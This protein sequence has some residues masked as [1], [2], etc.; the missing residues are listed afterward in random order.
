[1][2]KIILSSS[3]KHKIDEIRK[4]LEDLDVLVISKDDLGLSNF[5]VIEDGDTLEE[6]AIKKAKALSEKVDGIILADDTGLFVDYLNGE[7]GVRS[8]RF[9]GENASYLDNNIKLLKK[10][11]GIPL[12]KRTAKF[13]TVIAIVFEDKSIKTVLGECSGKIALKPSGE[14]GFGYDPLFIVDDY[15][16]TF[17]ELGEEIKNRISHRANALKKLKELLEREMNNENSSI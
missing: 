6:N 9:A 13:K 7:P 10:L 16:K 4:I 14:S 1:M 5:E 3:N 12:E 15:N 17:A 11:E 2:R 8:A